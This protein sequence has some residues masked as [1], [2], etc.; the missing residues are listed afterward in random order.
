MGGKLGQA[1]VKAG[2]VTAGQI[3]VALERQ[4]STRLPLGSLVVVLG[5]ISNAALDNVVARLS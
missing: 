3:S 4:R 1:L 2:F 5:F